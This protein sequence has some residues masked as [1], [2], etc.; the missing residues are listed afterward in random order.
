MMISGVFKQSV[1]FFF[2]SFVEEYATKKSY[3]LTGLVTLKSKR[4]TKKITGK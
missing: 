1:G 3:I 4:E 2:C